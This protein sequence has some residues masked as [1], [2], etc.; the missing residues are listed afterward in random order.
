MVYLA[1]VQ[2]F[3][4]KFRMAFF[5]A[6]PLYFFLEDPIFLAKSVGSELYRFTRFL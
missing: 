4:R 3:N 5:L 2:D 6:I 1:D